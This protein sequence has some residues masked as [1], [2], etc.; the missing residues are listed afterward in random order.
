MRGKLIWRG[1]SEGDAIKALIASGKWE[2][3]ASG[4]G[5]FWVRSRKF[6]DVVEVQ[7]DDHGTVTDIDI[8]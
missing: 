8:L 1:M 5:W 6:D 7:I 2:Y 4:S 3:I